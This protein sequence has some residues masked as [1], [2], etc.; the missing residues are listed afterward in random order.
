VGAEGGDAPTTPLWLAPL[1][2][3]ETVPARTRY[4]LA[5]GF[6]LTSLDRLPD[7]GYVALER[8]YAPIIGARARI[9]RFPA[10]ALEAGGDVL[11]DVEELA[12]LGPP[13]PV[14]NFEGISA[15][16]MPNG[17]TRLY[18]VSDDNFSSRQCTLLLA[19]DVVE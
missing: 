6:S 19:F 17:V 16:R 12:R 7:G 10:S 3:H 11:P 1:S 9:T 15:V 18:I 14:D 8:F 2:A 5:R 4:P 13:D